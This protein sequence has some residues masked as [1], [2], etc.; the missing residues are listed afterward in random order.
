MGNRG[1]IRF[2]ARRGSSG[3]HLFPSTETVFMLLCDQVPLSHLPSSLSF[4]IFCIPDLIW[5]GSSEFES[6]IGYDWV[7][8]MLLMKVRCYIRCGGWEI[9]KILVIA[10]VI[11][12]DWLLA[13]AVAG[14]L[15]QS[16]F[17]MM[18]EGWTWGL[19]FF[20]GSLGGT[21]QSSCCVCLLFRL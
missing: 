13:D 17:L 4:F 3:F 1:V 14:D 16:G 12:E 15:N 18:F 2:L 9:V 7:S 19:G 11:I 10:T 6:V 5:F 20:R 21:L 8:C